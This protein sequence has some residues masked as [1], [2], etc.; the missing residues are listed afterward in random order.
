MN[1]NV[2]PPTPAHRVL[3]VASGAMLAN[4]LKRTITLLDYKFCSR[5]QTNVQIFNKNSKP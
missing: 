2:R 5:I 3:S 1:L 4:Y